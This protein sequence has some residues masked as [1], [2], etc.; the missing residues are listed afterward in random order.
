MIR[1]YRV[2][3]YNFRLVI[4]L[5]VL[6]MIG[7]L[8][9]GS[10]DP[11]LKMKQLF[12]VL[13][14]IGI[15]IVVSLF[16]YAWVMQLYWVIYVV[17]IGLLIAVRIFGSN[18]KGASRWIVIG[19]FQFQPTEIA[20]ILLIMFFAMFFM[21]HENDINKFKTI[22]KSVVLLGIPAFLIFSQP[23]L[24]N[25]I[26]IVIL[27]CLLIYAAGI[28]Y[29]NIGRT[30]AVVIPLV[31][32]ALLLILKTDLPIIDNYQKERIM[33]KIYSE[34]EEFSDNTMQQDNSIMAIGS[35]QLAGK[36]AG[37]NTVSTANK[38]NF[39]PENQNDFI[40]AVAGEELGFIG[41]V[42]IIL[43]ITAIIYECIRLGRKAKDKAGMLLCIGLASNVAIQSFINMAVATGI[44]PN[45]GTP[46]PFVSYGL[47]SL[48]SLFI[49]M[50]LVLN[51]GLQRKKH[52]DETAL[53][54]K[55]SI[56]NNT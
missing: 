31:V 56:R 52:L 18:I 7:V 34:D 41:C 23:D 11:S 37:S 10:A 1:R 29:K 44:F 13:S 50:G 4:L 32:V 55:D 39:V 53:G 35:G 5:A 36:G 27:F 6:S 51:V 9:V 19:G 26:T 48:W 2:R 38:S 21:K 14:G 3:D 20:K 12:G 17:C 15:M 25:T 8:L 40:F 43:L 22:I 45:T 46:L 47:T 33:A 16:D 54:W 49:G 28:S 30:L 24:K 42:V